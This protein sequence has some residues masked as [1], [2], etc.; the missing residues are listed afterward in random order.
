MKM[1]A[2]KYLIVSGTLKDD[3]YNNERPLGTLMIF[4]KT[5]TSTVISS[6]PK[7]Y[8]GDSDAMRSVPY[9]FDIKKDEG[10]KCSLS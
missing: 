9:D 5:D 8:G 7:F 2:D 1:Y 6:S 10:N 3:Y 4:D